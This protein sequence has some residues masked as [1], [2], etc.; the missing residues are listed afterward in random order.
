MA[1]HFGVT[2][3]QMIAWMYTHKADVEEAVQQLQGARELA[4]KVFDDK[5]KEEEADGK[6]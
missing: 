5:D 4:A 6:H 3:K 1:E 2:P